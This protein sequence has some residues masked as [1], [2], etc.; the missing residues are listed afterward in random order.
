M[1]TTGQ[2]F[3]KIRTQ[4]KLA[5]EEFGKLIGLSKSA[6][7]AVENDKSFI[8]IDIQRTLYDKYNINLNWLVCGEGNMHNDINDKNSQF[9]EEIGQIIFEFLKQKEIIN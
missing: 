6:V 8:S 9:K 7:S 2:R 1:E 4:K 3:K 5:Q